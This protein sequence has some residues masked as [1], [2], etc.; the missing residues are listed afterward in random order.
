LKRGLFPNPFKHKKPK[1]DEE[2]VA[3]ARDHII[4]DKKIKAVDA[5][6]VALLGSARDHEILKEHLHK[7][8]R[9]ESDLFATALLR[10]TY[11]YSWERSKG[12]DQLPEYYEKAHWHEDRATQEHVIVQL[13][14]EAAE[15]E[16]K[17][18]EE[19]RTGIKRTEGPKKKKIDPPATLDFHH[20]RV[21]AAQGNIEKIN[22]LNHV[23]DEH[24][25]D[26]IRNLKKKSDTLQR[27]AEKT[28]RINDAVNLMHFYKKDSIRIQAKDDAERESKRAKKEKKEKKK[29]KQVSLGTSSQSTEIAPERSH[30]GY[31]STSGSGSE[32]EGRKSDSSSG[33]SSSSTARGRVSAPLSPDSLPNYDDAA[34]AKVEPARSALKG[35]Q[36][37]SEEEGKSGRRVTWGSSDSRHAPPSPGKSADSSS[38]SSPEYD[39]I[40][41]PTSVLPGNNNDVQEIYNE[42]DVDQKRKSKA[43][44]YAPKPAYRP[45]PRFLAMH[46]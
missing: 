2:R 6:I 38:H 36:S 37:I 33:G 25:Q 24:L 35:S 7:L 27:A 10:E 1:S 20:E 4:H 5:E 22:D 21:L 14:K 39:F 44:W 16:R 43:R 46:M 3:K 45:Q 23:L 29:G 28:E 42:H 19:R 31:A 12:L 32:S 18:K 30:T 41:S 26:M 15:E 34:R 13:K 8:D 9:Y 11:K 40:D 17:K